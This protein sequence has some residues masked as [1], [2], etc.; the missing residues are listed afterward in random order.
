MKKLLAATLLLSATVAFAKNPAQ[1]TKI[2]IHD[3]DHNGVPTFVTGE[4]GQLGAGATDKAAK[5]FLKSQSALL[6]MV[7]TE[8]FESLG[9]FLDSKGDTHVR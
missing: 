7:G 1:E 6:Q 5:A 9:T 3:M 8:D 2:K 4:L